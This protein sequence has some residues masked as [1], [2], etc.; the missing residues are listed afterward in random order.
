VLD[1]NI[2]RESNSKTLSAAETLPKALPKALT[3]PLIPP[4]LG[5][6]SGILFANALGISWRAGLLGAAI[7]SGLFLWARLRKSRYAHWVA[8]AAVFFWLAAAR[9]QYS[10]SDPAPVL[11]AAPREVVAIDVCVVSLPERERDRTLFWGEAAP[12]ARL[13]VSWYNGEDTVAPDLHY[14]ERY[15]LPV[16]VKPVRNAGNPGSFD[17]ERYMRHRGIFW[18]ASVASRM[19]FERLPGECGNAAQA[20]IY[21]LRASIMARIAA[22]SG[23]D[24]YLRAMLGALL[25]G[26]NSQLERAWTENYR[27]TGTYHAIVVSGLHVTVLAAALAFVLRWLFLP[28]NLA[29]LLCCLLAVLYALVCDLSAPVIRAAGGFVLYSLAQFFYRKARPLNLLAAVAIVFLLADPEQ[30]FDGS[31]QLSFLAVLALCALAAPLQELST[32]PWGAALYRLEDPKFRPTDPVAAELRLELR[33]A[34]EAISGPLRV[35]ARHCQRAAR[36]VFQPML[37]S[38][39]L[40]LTSAVVLVGLSLPTALFFHRLNFASLTANLPVVILLTLGVVAGFVAL[41]LGPIAAPALSALLAI[42]RDVV[43]WHLRWDSAGRVPDPPAWLVLALPGA[44]LATAVLARVRP[45]WALGAAAASLSLFL[46]LALHPYDR[47]PLLAAGKLEVA[48]IDIGQGDALFLA[49]PSRHLAILDGGGSR[50]D[51]FDPGESVLSPYLWT[52][53]INR[54]DTLIASHGDLDHIGGLLATYDN[55]QPREVWVSRQIRGPLWEKL[56][57]KAAGRVRYLA[58]GDRV[59]LGEVPVEVLWPPRDA[60]IG[61]TNLASLVLLVRHGCHSFLLTG[62][63][64]RSVETALLESGRLGRIDVLKVAHHGSKTSTSADFLEATRPALSLISA[65]YA[66]PF[67]HPH[68]DVVRR[69]DEAH[70]MVLRTDLLGQ[71]RILSD[72]RRLESDAFAYRERIAWSWLPLAAALE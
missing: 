52:R 15:R 46:Y 39:D 40:T 30:L 20:A 67:G 17:A 56:K 62:D 35:P 28:R 22:L 11:D 9:T 53:R 55:F 4:L 71:V 41:L 66:N 63:I 61:K 3:E 14:G 70:S 36:C 59:Q 69:L 7:T 43:D 47:E 24:A 25:I 8:G 37:F 72:G 16:R 2:Q 19:P 58:A 60:V 27:K 57:A 29:L 49:T 13:R 18:N 26:D 1:R 51:R 54:I 23:D 6:I 32:K 38:F 65:G 21:K 31:F 68:P 44:L 5:I 45:R 12:G 33:L 34:T 42:S 50:S 64:D 48:A 10:Q